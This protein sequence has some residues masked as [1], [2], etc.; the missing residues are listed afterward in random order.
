[1]K[2]FSELIKNDESNKS[3]ELAKHVRKIDGSITIVSKRSHVLEEVHSQLSRYNLRA[4]TEIESCIF[5]LKEHKKLSASESLV[6]DIE[7][8]TCIDKIIDIINIMVPA[9]TRFILVGDCDSISFSQNLTKRGISYLHIGSQ[10]ASLYALLNNLGDVNL[11][12]TDSLKISIIGCKGGVGTST[13]AYK[14]FHASSNLVS[15]PVLLVQGGEGS[16]DMDLI[17]EKPI[18]KDGSIVEI[19]DNQYARIE[20]NDSSWIYDDANFRRFNIIIFDHAIHG[21]QSD[22]I[23][24]VISESNTIILVITTDLSSIRVAKKTLDESK[25]ILL[26]RTELNPKIYLCLNETRPRRP[27]DLRV[28]DIEEYLGKKIDVIRAYQKSKK[29]NDTIT[30][31]MSTV[32]GKVATKKRNPITM[33]FSKKT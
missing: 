17:C 33:L 22:R 12:N 23:E 3:D 7:N 32:L 29:D 18:A 19:A 9:S 2:L 26:T 14:L 21:V 1:M 20:T 4:I 28:E 27:G 5:S 11:K 15:V 24:T 30:E 6:I 31:F 13:V 25:R 10:L 16:Q 8:E